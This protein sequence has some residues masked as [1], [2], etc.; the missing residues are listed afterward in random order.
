MLN[1]ILSI[2]ITILS[3]TIEYYSIN[4]TNAFPYYASN[5]SENGFMKVNM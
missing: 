2:I 5:S 4:T 3:I 1:T